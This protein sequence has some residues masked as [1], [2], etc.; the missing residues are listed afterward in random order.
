V[1]D[2]TEHQ[3]MHIWNT[4]WDTIGP[5]SMQTMLVS[6][7]S[8]DR[9]IVYLPAKKKVCQLR[10]MLG[11]TRYYRKF[12]KGYAQIKAPMEKLLR[13]DTKYQC[14][15]ECQDGMDTLKE[16]MVTAP[17]LVFP[18]WEKTFHVHVYAS[19]IALEAILA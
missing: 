3:E 14:N 18:E 2:I 10:A 13:K 1:S 17:I 4:V 6:G 11:H 12:I 9:V 15:D 8:Q 7:S 16:N 19:V 5:Y